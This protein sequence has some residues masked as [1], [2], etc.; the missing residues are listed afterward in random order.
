MTSCLLVP[1]NGDRPKG[2][3]RYG[4]VVFTVKV[5]QPRNNVHKH[6]DKPKISIGSAHVSMACQS[7]ATG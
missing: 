7:K 6:L 2:R 3:H 4:V 5:N 1:I